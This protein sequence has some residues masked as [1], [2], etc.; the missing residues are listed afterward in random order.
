MYLTEIVQ[1]AEVRFATHDLN[2]K[3]NTTPLEERGI[4]ST[5]AQLD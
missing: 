5:F 2:F 1:S 3:A 4:I